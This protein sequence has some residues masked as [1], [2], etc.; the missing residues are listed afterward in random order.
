MS[1]S[2][3]NPLVVMPNEIFSEMKEWLSQKE[4]KSNQHQEFIYSYIW[5]LSYYWRYAKYSEEK[6]TQQSIKSVLGYSPIDKRL[7][8]LIKK[9]GLLDNKEYTLSTKD[10]PIAWNF[11]DEVEGVSFTM[12]NDLDDAMKNMI[13]KFESENYLVKAPLISIGTEDSEGIY[14]NT[15]NTHFISLDVFQTCTSNLSLQCAGF[16]MCGLLKYL[17]DKSSHYNDSA[18]FECSNE[19]LADLTSWSM[20]RVSDVTSNLMSTGL[21]HKEQPVKSKG[22]RNTY[23]LF[24]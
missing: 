10:F 16:Y 22:Q 21:L 23:R 17:E 19:T 5:L 14:W 6:I 4:L 11:V 2:H 7:N 18:D 3:D 8:Y 24:Y 13:S 20:R 15:T 12:L 1:S 9:D